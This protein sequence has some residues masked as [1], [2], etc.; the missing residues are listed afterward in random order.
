MKIKVKAQGHKLTIPIPT[1]LLFGKTAIRLW[2]KIARSAVG[3]ASDRD[4]EA[5]HRIPD[6]AIAAFCEE[7][8]RVKKKHGHWDLVEVRSADGEEVLI[9]L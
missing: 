1:G 5:F 4:A 8:M 9:R 7:L 6:A 2:L 3:R